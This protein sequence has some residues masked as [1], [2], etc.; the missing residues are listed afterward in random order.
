M[1]D[2]PCQLKVPEKPPVRCPSCGARCSYDGYW[3]TC[4]ANC[5]RMGSWHP[6]SYPRWKIV[7][8]LWREKFLA[9]GCK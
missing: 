9:R 5:G 2:Y 4:S 3:L 8:R 7:V 1:T 6:G